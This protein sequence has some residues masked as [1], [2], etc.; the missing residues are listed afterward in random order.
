MQRMESQTS[1]SIW[2][3]IQYLDSPTDYREHL[4]R[5]AGL[6]PRQESEFLLLDTD[7]GRLWVWVWKFTLIAIVFSAGLFLFLES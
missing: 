6:A 3:T 5:E 1:V 4:A 2:R 7:S